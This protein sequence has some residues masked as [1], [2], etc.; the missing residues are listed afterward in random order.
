M[1]TPIRYLLDPGHII[2]ANDRDRHY[3]NASTLCKLYGVKRA[4]C[5][6][7][8]CLMDGERRQ[9]VLECPDLPIL[10][11]RYDGDYSLPGAS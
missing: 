7:L 9:I 2:S 4:E 6:D 5:I 8:S 10:A 1:A 3:I 11:P